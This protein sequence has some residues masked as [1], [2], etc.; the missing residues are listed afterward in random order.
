MRVHVEEVL[1]YLLPNLTIKLG[2]FGD[3]GNGMVIFM[4]VC[5]NK[6]SQVSSLSICTYLE[7]S[8]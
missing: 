1:D 4:C 7:S 6:N 5:I 3:K 8:H 2:L